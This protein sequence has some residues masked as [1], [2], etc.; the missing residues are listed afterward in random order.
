MR[1]DDGSQVGSHCANCPDMQLAVADTA[2]MAE[3]AHDYLKHL[4]D[5]G[6][7]VYNGLFEYILAQTFNSPLYLSDFER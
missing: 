5:D 7:T 2:F 4:N 3:H 1:C 6:Q